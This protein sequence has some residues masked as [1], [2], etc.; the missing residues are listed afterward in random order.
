MINQSSLLGIRNKSGHFHN[1]LTHMGVSKNRGTQNGVVYNGKP[2]FLMGDL[3]K[4]HHLRKPPYLILPTSGPRNMARGKGHDLVVGFQAPLFGSSLAP[5]KIL[6]KS[7]VSQFFT[8]GKAI[9]LSKARFRSFYFLVL[10][11]PW[12]ATNSS[13]MLSPISWKFPESP[14]YA[15]ILDGWLKLQK[16]L[17]F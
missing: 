15:S 8:S 2:C 3:G 6:I 17:P 5:A 12:P 1:N 14:M 10:F 13:K 16:Q 7:A 9:A 4:T 11:F